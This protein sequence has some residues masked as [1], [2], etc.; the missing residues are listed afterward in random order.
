MPLSTVTR[1]RMPAAARPTSIASRVR[2]PAGYS[3][4]VPAAVSSAETVQMERLANQQLCLESVARA[5]DDRDVV[6]EVGETLLQ[7]GGRGHRHRQR[8]CRVGLAECG[9]LAA[10]QVEGGGI[11]HPDP[12]GPGG[13]RA[14]VGELVDKDLTFAQHPAS[15]SGNQFTGIGEAAPP[16]IAF[17]KPGA[18]DLL[19]AGDSLGQGTL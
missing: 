6:A 4:Q 5:H 2:D 12:E 19:E 17:E 1:G 15:V 7:V 10:E 9:D 13:T 14:A 3:A 11:D 18:H 16:A 8:N